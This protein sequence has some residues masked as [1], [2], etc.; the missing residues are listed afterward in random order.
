MRSYKC[1]CF[2]T[3]V[4]CMYAHMYVCM[5]VQAYSAHYIKARSKQAHVYLDMHAHTLALGH[6]RTHKHFG[7]YFKIRPC[8]CGR[9]V[10]L[11]A[12]FQ[13]I[14]IRNSFEERIILIVCAF[15]FKCIFK[16]ISAHIKH[17]YLCIACARALQPYMNACN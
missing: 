12:R 13:K 5:Y 6:V 10:T 17:L 2:G 15:E 16:S 8:V 7:N 9:K 14:Q 4:V 3:A 11:R 1:A